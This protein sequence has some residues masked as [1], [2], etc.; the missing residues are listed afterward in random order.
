M[1]TNLVASKEELVKLARDLIDIY[2]KHQMD[3]NEFSLA[4]SMTIAQFIDDHED[5]DDAP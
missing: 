5:R 2:E 3:E 1:K 4:S